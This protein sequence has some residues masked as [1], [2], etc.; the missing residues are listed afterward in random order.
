MKFDHVYRPRLAGNSD[1][2]Q[3]S[4]FSRWLS[5]EKNPQELKGY[6]RPLVQPLEI[7]KAEGLDRLMF[8]GGIALKSQSEASR[9][10]THISLSSCSP[11]QTNFHEWISCVS[12][13]VHDP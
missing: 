13:R 5:Y 4:H 8:V 7:R 12:F 3:L 9:E 10:P 6:Y 2:S 11:D 1:K